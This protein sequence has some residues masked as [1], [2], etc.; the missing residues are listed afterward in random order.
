MQLQ[1]N[2]IKI[3]KW[4]TENEFKANEEVAIQIKQRRIKLNDRLKT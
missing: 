3:L 2:K 1:K 4:N